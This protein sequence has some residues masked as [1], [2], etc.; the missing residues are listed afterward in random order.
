MM[1]RWWRASASQA[2]SWWADEAGVG[3]LSTVLA[4]GVFSVVAVAAIWA[5]FQAAGIDIAEAI[6]DTILDAFT[7]GGGDGAAPSP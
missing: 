2:R 5:V 4:I 7:S 1:V 3:E 6:R